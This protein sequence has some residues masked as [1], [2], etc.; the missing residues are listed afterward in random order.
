M[1][2]LYEGKKIKSLFD[3]IPNT[4][5]SVI[6]IVFVVGSTAIFFSLEDMKNVVK[7][8]SLWMNFLIYIN[9]LK[10][11]ADGYTI[12][13]LKNVAPKEIDEAINRQ[14]AKYVDLSPLLG[15]VTEVGIG[16]EP[17][18]INIAPVPDS[19]VLSIDEE[20]QAYIDQL[21]DITPSQKSR[22]EVLSK[23]YKTVKIG[24][25][26]IEEILNEPVDLTIDKK[27]L[28]FL[29]DEIPDDS[30]LTSSVINLDE[31]YMTKLFQRDMS[32]VI[33]S[34]SKN[35][36]YLTDFEVTPQIDELNRVA[37]YR[38]TYENAQGKRST[39]KY[40]FPIIDKDGT[41]TI[42]GITNR[43]KKQQVNTPICKI[44]PT[45][46]SLAASYKTLV[47]RN[48]TKAHS[49]KDFITK[50]IDKVNKDKQVIETKLG[51]RVYTDRLPYEYTTLG[52]RYKSLRIGNNLIS[53]DYK[54][55][56]TLSKDPKAIK[57][58]SQYGVL[59]GKVV[60]K[61]NEM[62]YI[63]MDNNVRKVNIVSNDELEITSITDIIADNTDVLVPMVS[64]WTELKILDQKIPIIFILSYRY[65][66]ME[67]LKRL[68]IDYRLYDK[69]VKVENLPTDIVI[70]FNNKTL[71]VNRYP[72]QHSQILAGMLTY[73]T[74]KIDIEE[75][76][77]ANVY[78]DLLLS[79]RIST[80]YIKGI[81][82]FFELFLD[83][84]TKDVLQQMGEPTNIT[85]LL[86]RASGLLA[87]EDYIEPASM[88]NH[89]I[90][91]YSRMNSVLYDEMARKLAEH[92][93]QNRS[94][95][96]S[97]NPEA[98]FQRIAQDQAVGI[99]EDINPVHNIK[100]KTG[101]THTGVGGRTATSFVDRDRKYPKDGVGIISEAT[102][103]SGKVALTAYTSMDPRIANLRGLYDIVDDE[104][105][106]TEMLSITGILMPKV[107]GDDKHINLN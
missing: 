77:S 79:K 65:G 25:R 37:H 104:P 2:F 30:M 9:K 27:E 88:R 29:K 54:N 41:F 91:T 33:T 71:V 52:S 44:S 39:V 47:E 98:V 16:K 6:H 50:Y 21:E 72:I 57:L 18:P 78:Y 7:N 49:F 63:G 56:E 8:Q 102:P 84:I 15:D 36:L 74:N 5:R 51:G 100:D 11:S 62:L 24:N 107:T 90:R 67:A 40:K 48:T 103:D 59:V 31:Q 76:E 85:D 14:Q 89:M 99:V 101:Y 87:T 61:P 93:S 82:R 94:D 64:E 45:R 28:S 58:E 4:Y 60:G 55:R 43:M 17:E 92:R 83:P 26:T 13:E 80:N 12:D 70:K 69:G 19:P 105:E 42:N 86:I 22:L 1:T 32:Q 75:F 95:K 35:G 66:L 46:V 96:F 34:F 97:I 10:L 20:A 68:K 23:K 3:E 106:P 53:F 81:D 73:K 38:L